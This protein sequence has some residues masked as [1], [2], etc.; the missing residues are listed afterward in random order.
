MKLRTKLL[1]VSVTIIF[2]VSCALL[3][4][5]DVK[6]PVEQMTQ[7]VL[8]N[9]T[10][11]EV[12]LPLKE[13]PPDLADFFSWYQ[14]MIA[15]ASPAVL[16]VMR[17]FDPSFRASSLDRDKDIEQL[18]PTD[19]WLQKLLDMG[20]VIED[21]SDYS[22]YLNMRWEF[23]HAK[24]DPEDIETLIYKYRLDA[25]ASWD[26]IVDAGIRFGAKLH[27]LAEQAMEADPLVY[28][29]SMGRDG[30]FIPARLK[31][32]YVQDGSMSS[33]TGVPEW[34]GRELSYRQSGRPPSREIPK[35]IDII[36]LDEKGQPIKDRM[37]PSDDGGDMERFSNGETDAFG[38][39]ARD[40]K[41]LADDIDNS[42]PDD[43]PPPSNKKAFEFET[44]K[45]PKSMA[46]LE[47]QL[48]PEG[49]EA[50]LT[51]GLSADP[52]DKAQQLI[53][54]HGTEEGLRRLRESDPDAARQ[55]ERD[56]RPSRDA[57][58]SDES[59]PEDSP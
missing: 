48:T 7:Q 35:D 52:A 41:T 25:D 5:V 45:I 16:A 27:T 2:F 20:I 10:V 17:K 4:F 18:F 40:Q 36:Y 28:G 9:P 42:F 34:V 30:V 33:G 3:L 37:P 11:T 56:R 54:Q 22:G 8:D 13:M 51:E 32:V 26:E 44:P 58:K 59:P 21:F 39:A 29:G 38:A 47:K 23:Y 15:D 31:T 19:E 53:D 1:I 55:F 14:P 12:E 6:V 43:I 24:N 49:I 46:D 57:P 50:E